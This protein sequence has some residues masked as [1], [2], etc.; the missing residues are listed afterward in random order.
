MAGYCAI[1]ITK[2]LQDLTE[3]EH[4]KR[5]YRLCFEHYVTKIQKLRGHVEEKVCTA[6]ISLASAEPLP[7]YNGT[8]AV[9]RAGG[10]KA[11]G[12]FFQNPLWI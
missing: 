10:K 3:Y 9:I 5:V 8:L 4:L 6:M 7:D 11:A 1:E 2:A 12:I